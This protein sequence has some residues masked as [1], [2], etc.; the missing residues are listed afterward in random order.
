MAKQDRQTEGELR[1]ATSEF[2]PLANCLPMKRP[3]TAR[4]HRIDGGADRGRE[5]NSSG[6]LMLR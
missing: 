1:A 2:R 3:A 5:E 4:R 6:F